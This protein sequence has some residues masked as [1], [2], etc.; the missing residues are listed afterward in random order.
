MDKSAD[1]DVADI[2]AEIKQEVAGMQNS[3]VD[4]LFKNIKIDL[5][6]GNNVSLLRFDK[7]ASDLPQ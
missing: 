4:S 2:E 7:L 5:Q 3:I 1:N 6:C